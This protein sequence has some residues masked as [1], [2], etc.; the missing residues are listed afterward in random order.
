MKFLV[1]ASHLARLVGLFASHLLL[2]K[3]L[4]FQPPLQKEDI[5]AGSVTSLPLKKKS[6]S[7]KRKSTNFDIISNNQST[8]VVTRSMTRAVATIVTKRTVV[9]ASL[10]STD[11]SNYNIHDGVSRTLSVDPL[12]GTSIFEVEDLQQRF[13]CN[14]TKDSGLFAI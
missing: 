2:L 13:F 11:N 10:H 3:T 6:G 14:I 12:K 1:F 8:G 4:N 5:A 9:V 7:L